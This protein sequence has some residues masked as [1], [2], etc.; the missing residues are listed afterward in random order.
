[1]LQHEVRDRRGLAGRLDFWDP[2]RRIGGEVDGAKKYLDPALAT[3]GAG[4]AVYEEKL[5][6]DRVRACIERLA[7]WGWQ[8]SGDPLR[9]GPRLAAAGV[10]PSSP[11]ATL[12]DYVA[13]ARPFG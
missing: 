8:E 11:A 4:R 10:L 9:L 6:E 7:R 12:A 1:V 3:Q 5:R 13:A 2:I